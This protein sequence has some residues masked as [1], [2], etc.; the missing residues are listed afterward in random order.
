MSEQNP[1]GKDQIPQE[2]VAEIARSWMD[3]AFL[4]HNAVRSGVVERLRNCGPEA[5]YRDGASLVSTNWQHDDILTVYEVTV[6]T[7]VTPDPIIDTLLNGYDR[8]YL[9]A[10][11]E[12]LILHAQLIDSQAT[13]TLQCWSL[14]PVIDQSAIS[15][16][17]AL[18][19]TFLADD[20]QL[21]LYKMRGNHC[22]ADMV[23][24]TS[25]GGFRN[26]VLQSRIDIL[27]SRSDTVGS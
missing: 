3:D 17:F 10:L 6:S 16:Q 4:S 9:D 15:R 1:H 23:L 27:D 8:T 5:E 25:E 21:I 13:A 2:L 7:S 26:V 18:L 12:S 20:E 24:T 11:L 22:V 14:N 19:K